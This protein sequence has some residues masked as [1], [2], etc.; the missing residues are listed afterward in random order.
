MSVQFPRSPQTNNRIRIPCGSASYRFLPICLFFDRFIAS[1]TLPA[2][3]SKPVTIRGHTCA[4]R[5]QNNRARARPRV[6]DISPGDPG[7]FRPPDAYKYTLHV[8][9]IC[10]KKIKKQNTTQPGLSHE[11]GRHTLLP[12]RASSSSSV[13]HTASALYPPRRVRAAASSK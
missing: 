11:K 10:A 8:I 9:Y 13:Y 12:R 6:P 5:E 7:K 3:T 2:G 4:S 1:S